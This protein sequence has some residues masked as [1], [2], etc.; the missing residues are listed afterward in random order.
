MCTA[1]PRLRGVYRAEMEQHK[2]TKHTR[3]VSEE[4]GE[5]VEEGE[6]GGRGGRPFYIANTHILVF[7]CLCLLCVCD[8]DG[9]I[10]A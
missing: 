5:L 9:R 6:K 4:V 3:F 7:D 1:K 8:F 2:Q 10:S